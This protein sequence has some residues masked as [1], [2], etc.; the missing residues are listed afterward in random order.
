MNHAGAF[1][2]GDNVDLAASNIDAG[3][4]NFLPRVGG[5]NCGRNLKKVIAAASESRI[6]L[7]KSIH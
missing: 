6:N 7:R 5:H 2:E 4:R 1:T 3:E